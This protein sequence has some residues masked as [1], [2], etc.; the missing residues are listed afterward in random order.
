[1]ARPTG[2]RSFSREAGASVEQLN[3]R[4]PEM[5]ACHAFS[6][7]AEP[8]DALVPPNWIGSQRLPGVSLGLLHAPSPIST[9]CCPIRAQVLQTHTNLGWPCVRAGGDALGDG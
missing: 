2:Q 5:N 6:F 3:K 9:L 1:M 8:G 7:N 4:P